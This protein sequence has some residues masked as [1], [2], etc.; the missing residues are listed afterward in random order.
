MRSRLNLSAVLALAS[1]VAVR[2]V[3]AA[4]PILGQ[5]WPAYKSATQSVSQV[6][7]SYSSKNGIAYYFVTVT[8]QTGFSLPPDQPESDVQAF[9]TEAKAHGVRPVFSVGGWSGSIYFSDLVATAAE[10]VTFARQLKAFMD[11]YG[12]VGVDLDWEYPNG[13]GLGCNKRRPDDSTNLL[14]FLKVLRAEIGR[15]KLITAAVPASGF[16]GPDGKALRS[17]AAFANE[18]DYI[19]LMTYDMSGS[20]SA[21]T[22]PHSPLRKCRSDSSAWTAVKLW[23]SR[24]FPASKILLGIPSYAVSFT[25]RESK[26]ATV[27]IDNGRW[28]SKAYQAW[29]GVVPQG[30]A[31]DS[32]VGS[33]VTDPC[34]VTTTGRSGANGYVR[35]WDACTA[36]PF[37][38]NPSKKHYI[39]YE[40]SKSAGMKAEW[41]AKQ[42]LAG[43]FL[44]DSTGFDATVYDA[45]TAGLYSRKARRA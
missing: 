42:G 24:G 6:P 8:T 9:V 45:I 20:W 2:G 1:A 7:W 25:T 40:D 43:V 32:N 30:A 37:L 36:V 38:F 17:F 19:N 33:S 21:T 14:A 22:G 34:G 10:R 15:D 39:S 18:M 27:S 28:Q 35:Y 16:R 23:T 12:F 13:E 4:A 5:Y 3:S 41:A 11:K 26:L 29:T 31:G 44:F